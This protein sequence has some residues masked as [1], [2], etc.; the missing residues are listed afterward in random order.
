MFWGSN[1]DSALDF[2]EAFFR[3]GVAVLFAY[4]G[5]RSLPKGEVLLEVR[6]CASR[7]EA[8]AFLRQY[9]HRMIRIGLDTRY[10]GLA[11]PIKIGGKHTLD[12]LDTIHPPTFFIERSVGRDPHAVAAWRFIRPATIDQATRTVEDFAADFAAKHG[13]AV[14]LI[15]SPVP[16]TGSGWETIRLGKA[17][18]H[19]DSLKP[20][21]AAPIAEAADGFVPASTRQPGNVDWMMEDWFA[22]GV[23]HI[24]YGP[25]G[26]AKTTWAADLAAIVSRGGQFFN[27][28]SCAPGGV[29]MYECEQGDLNNNLVPQLIASGAN[30]DRIHLE[31]EPVDLS[32]LAGMRKL[33]AIRTGMK[34]RGIRMAL[35]ILSPHLSFFGEPTNDELTVRKRRDKLD[36]W[37]SKNRVCIISIMHQ[38]GTSEDRTSGSQ[39]HL[40]VS[41]AAFLMRYDPKM[42]GRPKQRQILPTKNNN[43]P[44]DMLVNYTTQ[45]CRI[46]RPSDGREVG[47]WRFVF[48]SMKTDENADEDF[49]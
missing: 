9:R 19:I 5:D 4:G 41:R 11:V 44:M 37:A 1:F 26:V 16:D 2:I 43:G 14:P 46:R 42:K 23:S 8:S 7:S 10:I 40:K 22:Y 27:S 30:M 18:I 34:A 36:R 38:S 25:P 24:V 3:D 31:N 17:A 35:L 20:R 12:I 15:A 13:R 6:N 28:K 29:C 45:G 21:G 39:A 48:Q 49:A 32:S 47:T 33:E